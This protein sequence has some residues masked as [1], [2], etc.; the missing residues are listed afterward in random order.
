MM[1]AIRFT[2]PL[3]DAV[4]SAVSALMALALIGIGA[5]A[6]ARPAAPSSSELATPRAAPASTG[7]RELDPSGPPTTDEQL[8]AQLFERRHDLLA[9]CDVV[10]AELEDRRRAM[11][12]IGAQLAA[13]M[14]A[15][16]AA[17]IAQNAATAATGRPEPMPPPASPSA[18]VTGAVRLQTR[19][20]DV[21]AGMHTLVSARTNS[22]ILDALDHLA[23]RCARAD[24]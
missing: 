1:R 14:T 18:D 17:G 2:R 20:G 7:W 16:L 22:E 24:R 10:L 12:P 3:P 9:R 11:G 4:R 15:Q 13:N 6:A 8:R 5:C 19:I 23:P 21:R